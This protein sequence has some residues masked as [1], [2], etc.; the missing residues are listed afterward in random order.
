MLGQGEVFYL[1]LNRQSSKLRRIES[2]NK[3]PL[4]TRKVAELALSLA[5]ADQE[6][7]TKI[8]SELQSI[9]KEH[10]LEIE[11]LVGLWNDLGTYISSHQ[12]EKPKEPLLV[13]EALLAL[14][15]SAADLDRSA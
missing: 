14:N 4:P 1:D 12:R 9:F 10:W 15:R 8:Q 11:A 3:A 7:C 5:E 13:D 2:M 6:T